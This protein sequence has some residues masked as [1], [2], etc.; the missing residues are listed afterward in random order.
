MNDAIVTADAGRAAAAE[1]GDADGVATGMGDAPQVAASSGGSA[2]VGERA[3]EGADDLSLPSFN[4]A[5]EDEAPE[6]GGLSM[7]QP[8]WVLLIPM[9]GF[10][11]PRW[12]G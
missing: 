4:P 7:G 8:G 12:A 6:G 11:P 5:I 10:R 2:L 9:S 3:G 1:G